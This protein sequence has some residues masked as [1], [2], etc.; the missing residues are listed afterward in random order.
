M[1]FQVFNIKFAIFLNFLYIIRKIL[2]LLLIFR[3]IYGIIN[4][5]IN[6]NSAV[7]TA[8]MERKS[9][10]VKTLHKMRYIPH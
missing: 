7:Y 10:Y 9:N 8:A 1:T 5:C 4:K 2:R 3:Q 6:N